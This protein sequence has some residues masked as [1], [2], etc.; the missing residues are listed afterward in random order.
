M[1][2]W[3]LFSVSRKGQ[4]PVVGSA[5]CSHV[6]VSTGVGVK[7]KTKGEISSLEHRGRGRGL[8]VG[9]EVTKQTGYEGQASGQ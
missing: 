9:Y 3:D 8:V 2:M 4:R 6:A 5:S 7:E 1:L